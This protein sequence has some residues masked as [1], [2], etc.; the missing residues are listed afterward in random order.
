MIDRVYSDGDIVTGLIG[1]CHKGREEAEK[2][3]QSIIVEHNLRVDLPNETFRL[4]EDQYNE[5]VK[6][7]SAEV[8]TMIWESKRWKA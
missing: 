1:Y 3:Y 5:F 4:T 6:R 8:G 7:F 2:L